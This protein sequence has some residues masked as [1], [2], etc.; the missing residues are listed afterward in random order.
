MKP[1]A[2]WLTRFTSWFFNTS[3]EWVPPAEEESAAARNPAAG[4]TPRPAPRKSPRD[5]SDAREAEKPDQR[6]R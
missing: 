4:E 3:P 1:R 2:P 6:S 5:A